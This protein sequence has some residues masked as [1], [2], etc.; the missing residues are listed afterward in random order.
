MSLNK[1]QLLDF[2]EE[3]DK[4][5]ERKITVVAVGGTAMTLHNAKASTID[6]DFTITAEDF[7]EFHRVLDLVP[8][9]FKVDTWNNGMVFSQDLPEDYLEKSKPVR[10]KMKNMKLRTLDPLDIIITKIGRLNERDKED[11]ATC[12]R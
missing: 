2:L 5:L 11:I 7:G 4:E 12:I 1:R 3:L 8:H 6:V 9:G 10:T